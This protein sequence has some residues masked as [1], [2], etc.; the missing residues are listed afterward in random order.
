MP[1]GPRPPRIEWRTLVVADVEPLQF[2]QNL[3]MGLQMLTDGGFNVIS[4]HMRGVA[5]IVLAQRAVQEQ[6]QPAPGP[7][8]PAPPQPTPLSRLRAQSV[9]A[10]EERFTYHF[11][12]PE[13][14]QEQTFTSMV[15]AL[16]LVRAHVDGDGS[17]VPGYLVSMSVTTFEPPALLGLLKAYADDIAVT[18]PKQVD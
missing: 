14:P 16:R 9:G 1:R 10:N 12:S 13:G 8:M 11:L 7:T 2:A 5:Q 4:M 15:E 17:F 6:P 3:Q 18:P